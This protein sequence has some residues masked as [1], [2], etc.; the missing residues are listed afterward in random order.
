[1]KTYIALLRGIN[2]SGQKKIRMAELKSHIE[3]L[4]L[5]YVRTYIQSGNLVFHSEKS[6][7]RDIEV[8][9]EKNIL[10]NY[11]FNVSV[12]VKQPQELQ[13]VLENNP[14]ATDS[15]KDTNRT[16]FTF[17]SKEPML[18]DVEK[19]KTQDYFPEEFRLIGKTIY[20]YSPNGYGNAKM[21][22]NFFAKKLK[23]NATTRNYKTM[24]KLLEMAQNI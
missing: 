10:V 15:Q 7:P 22:N 13:V 20:F 3:K 2:V 9:I 4:G 19:I 18:P 24:N 14:Y 17:L 12:I 16:Y 8:L 23:V 5:L 21:N 11:G 1:M 6:D